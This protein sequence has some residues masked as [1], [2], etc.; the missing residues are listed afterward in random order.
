MKTVVE[1]HAEGL[2]A[3]FEIELEIYE[4][5]QFT[6]LCAQANGDFLTSD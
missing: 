1:K 3:E 6:A 4:R 2:L 5:A